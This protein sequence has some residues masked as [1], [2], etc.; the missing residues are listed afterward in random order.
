MHQPRIQAANRRRVSPR[1]RIANHTTRQDTNRHTTGHYSSITV[2]LLI[3]R[4]NT[5]PVPA[6]TRASVLSILPVFASNDRE[7][8]PNRSKIHRT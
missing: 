6:D 7:Y 8:E 5:T 1:L 4:E 2:G 3:A